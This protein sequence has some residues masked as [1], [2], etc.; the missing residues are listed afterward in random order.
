M[1]TCWMRLTRMLRPRQTL[2]TPACMR[3]SLGLIASLGLG[4]RSVVRYPLR[5]YIAKNIRRLRMLYERCCY[6]DVTHG[7]IVMPCPVRGGAYMCN[8]SPPRVGNLT[9][10]WISLDYVLVS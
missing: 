1:M 10:D 3:T 7:Q 9:P 6:G 2:I 5:D 4:T 8:S